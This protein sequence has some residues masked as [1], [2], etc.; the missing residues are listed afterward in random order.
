MVAWSQVLH[1]AAGDVDD[2]QMR[3]PFGLPLGPMAV[4]Q[5]GVAARLHLVVFLGI[6][7]GLVAG[8]VRAIGVHVAGEH[9]LLAIRRE[10]HAAGFGG[11]VG[12]LASI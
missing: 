12:D 4:E 11:K 2:H 3:A 1:R 9:Q 5:R 10:D 7:A 6:Q 8:V